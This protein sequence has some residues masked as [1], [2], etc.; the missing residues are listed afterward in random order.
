MRGRRTLP[1]AAKELTGNPRKPPLN[2]DEPQ[3]PRIIP[4]CPKHLDENARKEW[5]RISLE[6]HRLN[7]LTIVDRAAL[8]AY[9]PRAWGRWVEAEEHIQ[10]FGAV[11]KTLKG[12]SLV[13]PFLRIAEAGHRP[14]AQIPGRV[15][16]DAQLANPH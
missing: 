1:T 10:R 12:L 14:D 11:I 8:A 7:L 3:P 5:R 13:N 15:R 4:N 16:H 9:C 2:L 6:L